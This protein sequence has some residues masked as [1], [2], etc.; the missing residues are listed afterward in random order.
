MTNTYGK[1]IGEE[2]KEK[3]EKENNKKSVISK[4]FMRI[5]LILAGGAIIYFL[6]IFFFWIY[7]KNMD[8]VAGSE[9]FE[10]VSDITENVITPTG[11]EP[12]PPVSSKYLIGFDYSDYN[13]SSSVIIC[14]VRYDKKIEAEYKYTLSTTD[15]PAVQDVRCVTKTFDLTEEQY[16]NISKGIDLG[17][18]YNT[19]PMESKIED[20]SDG[21]SSCLLIYGE[22]DNVLKTIGGFAPRSDYYKSIR[23]LIYDN[24]P[25]EFTDGYTEY[26]RIN[27]Y[28]KM[29]ESL[30]YG[31][32]LNY[33]ED[34]NSLSY[35]NVIVI[36][37]QYHSKEEIES[38]K[39]YSHY[40]FSYINVGSLETFRSYYSEYED[41]TLSDYEN[42]EDE[43]WMDVSDER[44]QNYIIDTVAKDMVDK[45]IDGFFVDN[46][47]VYEHYS[48][49]GILDGLSNI[50]TGLK[51]YGK[52]V[53]MNGGDVFLDSY[54]VKKGEWSDVIDGINQENVFT[55]ID[56]DNGTLSLN[57]DEERK[58]F[59]DYI[60]KY[61]ALGAYI[62]LLE[63]TDNEGTKSD[64]VKYCKEHKYQYYISDSVELD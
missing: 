56:W 26:E 55:M 24:L 27:T 15:F 16:N 45:G 8:K 2:M 62:Y 1:N 54:C 10:V 51:G 21:S 36:D 57:D 47:D 42:W 6:C 9:A 41:L 35:K 43:R 30:D 13:L 50:M 31:V 60:E 14:K 38:F 32:Y 40:V 53:I 11:S 52:V 17:K 49:D 48:N 28:F 7:E 4:P 63:Y 18:L 58:Y 33:D 23:K 3:K 22:D 64:I 5:L 29:F 25:Q 39:N 37:A 44:W 46:C 59:T 12:L 34:L 61:S 19:D 20:V